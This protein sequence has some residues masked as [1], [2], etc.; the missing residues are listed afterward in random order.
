MNTPVN[1]IKV[2]ASNK[3]VVERTPGDNCNCEPPYLPCPLDNECLT[4]GV[5]YNA[6]VTATMPAPLP[7]AANPSPL[8]ITKEEKYTGLSI[9]TAK[10]R[11]TGHN[12]NIKH[13]EQ[14]GT[15]LS[16]HIWELKD[17]GIPYDL[18]WSI[19]ITASANGFNPSTRQCCLCLLEGWVVLFLNKRLQIFSRCWHKSRL[20]LNPKAFKDN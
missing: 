14:K 16:A 15:R 1:P 8:P 5:I 20:T 2:V 12:G 10:K 18:T 11:I 19:L 7:S 4:A 13:R 9:N 17:Q 6:K 3:P